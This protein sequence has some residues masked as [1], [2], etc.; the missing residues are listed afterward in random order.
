MCMS[1]TEIKGDIP[2]HV[3]VNS[4]VLFGYPDEHKLPRTEY[5]EEAIYWNKYDVQREHSQRSI[6]KPF[7]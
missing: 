7:L 6:D 1:N 4:I 3:A 2:A 5:T